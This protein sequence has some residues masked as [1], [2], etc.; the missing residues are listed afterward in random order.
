MAENQNGLPVTEESAPAVS[1]AEDDDG[2][3]IGPGL[4]AHRR[5]KRPLRFEQAFLESLPCANMYEKS[6]MHRD[7]VT[8]VAVSAADFFVTGSADGHIK[9]WKKKPIGI[10]FAKH[11]R[12]H[13]G[14][15]EGLA[16]SAD[17]LFCC[18]I[19]N[20]KS[21]KVYDV[22]NYD[23]MVMIRMPF[24]PGTVEWVYRHG[25]VKAKFAISDRHSPMVYIYDARA[26]SNE[27][28]ASRKIHTSPIMAMKYNQLFDAVI[29]ADTKGILEYWCPNTLAFP[30][31]GVKFKLK[32]ETDLF[33]VAKGRTTVS[34][35]EV[36]PD[37]NQFVIT[38]P[39]RRI[40]V[41]WY[42][43]GKLRRVYGESLEAAQELQRKDAPL[44]QLEAIDFGRRMAVEKEIEKTENAPQPNA[45]LDESG[46]FLIYTTLLGI[47]IVNLHT[48]KVARI[49][50]KFESNERFLR[51]ALYQ[52][53]KSSKKARK[54]PMTASNVNES[55]E[56]LSDP[57]FLCCAFKK[58]RIYLFSRR[59]PEEAE[60]AT[61]GRDVFNE[62]PPPEEL[63]AVSD[64]GK[65][66][67]TSLPDSVILHTSMGDIH[68]RLYPEECPRTVENFTTHCRN[69]YYDNLIF[70]RVIK[71]F[72]VQT[73]DP[74]GD[75]TGGQSIWG[76][77]FEDEF[78]K[79]LRHDRPFT[80]SMANAGPNTNGSQFFITTVA[81]PWLDNKHTV[82][83]RVVKGMDVV[84][85]IEKVKTDK[86]DKP[87]QD[88]KI[89]NVT[90]PK[91]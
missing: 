10:E 91:S 26:G 41:F 77:E 3:M 43:T 31:E 27:P 33:V 18:T 28:I 6:Y 42:K 70:H 16:V 73:G 51:L 63:L 11:F 76:R 45:V 22:V 19:S 58:H 78:H 30:E 32:T 48:N 36:S 88:V 29:S 44:Y 57:T 9:F 59:E 25:D 74:L 72:M 69:G 4:A 13:L 55:K 65:A 5:P 60:D 64:L 68:M 34:A 66:I 75:G 24:I 46:N 21:V 47:K 12:S 8:H 82:F 71:G 23:M 50:G 81:T 37:G 87:Y 7:V 67:T 2:P 35:L 49:L 86:N 17:G 89:L 85:L 15:I 83:G 62:K 80:L 38:S 20:D 79:S 40:R 1:V 53:D 61:K 84:Q 14:P 90:V 54:I 52:G 56:P 39:D